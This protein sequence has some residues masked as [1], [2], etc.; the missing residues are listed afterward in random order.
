M[1][2][3]IEVCRYLGANGAFETVVASPSWQHELG[4]LGDFHPR[5]VQAKYEEMPWLL[6]N[7]RIGLSMCRDDAGESLKA[8]MPTK[9]AEFLAIGRPVVVNSGLRDAAIIVAKYHCGVVVHATETP[10]A[11]GRRIEA[12]LED[13]DLEARCRLAA[14]ENFSLEKAARTL[15]AIYL[16]AVRES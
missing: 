5:V 14:E 13:K 4:D 6:G 15:E 11:I 2:R 1:T 3:M 7:S 8:A 12:L 16:R 10:E 9:I